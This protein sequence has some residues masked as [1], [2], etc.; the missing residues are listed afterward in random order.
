MDERLVS[1]VK[2]RWIERK[3]RKPIQG[4]DSAVSREEVIAYVDLEQQLAIWILLMIED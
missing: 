4:D 2:W 3:N 1:R